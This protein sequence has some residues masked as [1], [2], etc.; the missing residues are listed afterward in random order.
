MFGQHN[1]GPRIL[2]VVIEYVPE[3]KRVIVR[4]VWV[5]GE[6]S[7]VEK[8]TPDSTQNYVDV[9]EGVDMRWNVGFGGLEP[10]LAYR[11]PGAVGEG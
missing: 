6:V 10:S 9:F 7:A 1:D 8:L 11:A 4:G 3:Q 5:K 2:T